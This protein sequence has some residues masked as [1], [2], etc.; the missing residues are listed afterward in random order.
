MC[1]SSTSISWAY[2]KSK[3]G[4]DRRLASARKHRLVRRVG[5]M[6][7]VRAVVTRGT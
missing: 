3:A 5:G 4:F 6:A 2:I 7:I 1:W